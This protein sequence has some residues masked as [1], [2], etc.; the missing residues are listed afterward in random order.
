M[1]LYFRQVLIWQEF[2][3]LLNDRNNKALV[4]R[5]MGNLLCGSDVCCLYICFI[6][7]DFI[8]GFELMGVLLYTGCD[9]SSMSSLQFV[10]RNCFHFEMKGFRFPSCCPC[11]QPLQQKLMSLNTELEQIDPVVYRL[12][13]GWSEKMRNL[14]FDLEAL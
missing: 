4:R 9:S 11:M 5:H 1:Y 8:G 13:L 14:L 12:A 10:K 2:Q 3:V 6:S 7:C